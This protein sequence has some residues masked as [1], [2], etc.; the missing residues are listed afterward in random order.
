MI[1][2]FNLAD[3]PAAALAPYDLRG[4]HP[5]E[6]MTALLQEAEPEVIAVLQE[7]RARRRRPPINE[8]DFLAL[9]ERQGLKK[10]TAALRQFSVKL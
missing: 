8:T 1:I 6:F 10:F 9:L 2:T 4:I 5:D 3:F 7:M